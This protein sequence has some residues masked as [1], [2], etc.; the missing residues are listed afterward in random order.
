MHGLPGPL[1]SLHNPA[2]AHT[3]DSG[4][5]QVICSARW[6]WGLS[7]LTPWLPSPHSP[8]GYVVQ[9]HM[10]AGEQMRKCKGSHHSVFAE[11]LLVIPKG[12][13]PGACSESPCMKAVEGHLL[14]DGKA[15][16]KKVMVCCP[17]SRA[18]LSGQP[19]LEWFR[20]LHPPPPTS[21]EGNLH[22]G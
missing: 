5:A 17:L 18:S 13:A 22:S 21:L 14:T 12:D 10:L 8:T 20:I 16:R 11:H 9:G 15:Q 2:P 1:L 19:S 4:S 7:S 3:Q 6:A